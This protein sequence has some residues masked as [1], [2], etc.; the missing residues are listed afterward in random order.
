MSEHFRHG[1]HRGES[2]RGLQNLV[3]HPEAPDANL[4]DCLPFGHV[5]GLQ[6]LHQA[7]LRP[8]PEA[9]FRIARAETLMQQVRDLPIDGRENTKVATKIDWV[10]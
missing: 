9:E 6:A 1:P 8:L 3:H 2:V 10:L 5:A 4:N 7:G